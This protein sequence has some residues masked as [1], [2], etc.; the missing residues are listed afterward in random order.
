MWQE[1]TLIYTGLYYLGTVERGIKLRTKMV[2]FETSFNNWE[3]N[4]TALICRHAILEAI[5]HFRED[6]NLPSKN[7]RK[8]F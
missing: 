7:R 2:L 5:L 6:N 4:K 8:E 3:A 1:H